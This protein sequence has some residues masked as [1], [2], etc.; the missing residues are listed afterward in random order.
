MGYRQSECLHVG[1]GGA[2]M[3]FGAWGSEANTL[4]RLTRRVAVSFNWV[5]IPPAFGSFGAAV[6]CWSGRD[7][8]QFVGRE[9]MLLANVAL[10]SFIG[11]WILFT[12]LLPLV[13]TIE[14]IVLAHVLRIPL[15]KSFDTAVHANWRSTVA[16]LPAGWCMALVGLVPAGIL[17]CLLPP[18]YRDPSF[19]I[20]AFTALTGGIIPTRFTMIAMAA[21][22]LLILIPYYIATVR[23]ERKIVES[24]HP[25]LDPK[26]IAF[27][28]RSMN[29]ITYSVLGI[30]VLWWLVTAIANYGTGL[31]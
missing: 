15:L 3:L 9:N 24:R 4:S 16:G 8:N 18:R 1:E 12:V 25:E 19:Q 29:R 7:R 28:V 26:L 2:T 5:S 20:L 17:A 21:G 27:G 23:V 30:L 6:L 14:A 10:P 13:A 22:N 31:N 11:H